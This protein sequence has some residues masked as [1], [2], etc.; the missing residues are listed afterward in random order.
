MLQSD[1]TDPPFS[2]PPLPDP[3]NDVFNDSKMIYIVVS[4]YVAE[5]ASYAF[6]KAGQLETN[7]TSDQV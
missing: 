1:P 2:A 5:S 3:S 4:K 6:M 7:I